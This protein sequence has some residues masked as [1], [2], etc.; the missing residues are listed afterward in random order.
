MKQLEL[1][2]PPPLVVVIIALLMWI[3]A[4]FSPSINL[5]EQYKYFFL[6]IFIFDGLLLMLLS[7]WQFKKVKTTINPMRPNNSSTLV[8]TGFFSFSRNPIYVADLIILIGWGLFLANLFSL[9][10]IALF[11][12]YMNR[13]QIIPEERSLEELFGEQYLD[14]KAKVRRWI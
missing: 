13:F 12:L 7:A 1:K 4:K 6:V 2:I 9:V 3:V 10:L 5:L 8:T 14:Y 11:V